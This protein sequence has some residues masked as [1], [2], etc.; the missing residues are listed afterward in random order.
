[1]EAQGRAMITDQ[2]RRELDERGF[3]FTDVVFTA[4]ELEPVRRECLRLYRDSIEKIPESNPSHRTKQRLRPFLPS[5][6]EGSEIVARFSR[7]RV[8]QDLARAIISADVD[9]TWSQGCLKLPDVG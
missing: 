2:Q 4:D 8:F 1:M 9:Q 6:H 7:H 3:F 5:P